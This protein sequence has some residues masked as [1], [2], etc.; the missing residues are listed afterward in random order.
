M[1]I[2]NKLYETKE[3]L[4]KK[5]CLSTL[6]IFVLSAADKAAEIVHQM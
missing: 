2:E 1:C 6:D 4:K 5:N 3:Y